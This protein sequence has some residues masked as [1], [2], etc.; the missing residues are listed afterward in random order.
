MSNK[1]WPCQLHHNPQEKEKFSRV[2]GVE[3]KYQADCAHS[4]DVAQADKGGQQTQ[5]E[6]DGGGSR[7]GYR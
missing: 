4:S 3:C 5:A 6:E 1:C 2:Q 7:Y